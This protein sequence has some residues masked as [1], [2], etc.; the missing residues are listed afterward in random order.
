MTEQI[1]YDI[2]EKHAVSMGEFI[3]FLV[4]AG[5][6]I[7]VIMSVTKDGEQNEDKEFIRTMEI[8]IIPNGMVKERLSVGDVHRIHRVLQ[9]MIEAG[10]AR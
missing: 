1:F 4:D 10:V 2:G 8:D 3:A 6:D 9:A 5:T 7:A